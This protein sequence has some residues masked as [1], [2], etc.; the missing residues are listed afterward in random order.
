[1]NK[2]FWIFTC[3]L[4]CAF[5][6]YG[7]SRHALLVGCNYGGDGLERLRYAEKDAGLFA[8][9]LKKAGDFPAGQVKRLLRP[10]R[11]EF[12]KEMGKIG[13]KLQAD[14]DRENSMFLFYFSGH[15][16]GESLLLDREKVSL[17]RIKGFLDSC[18][19]GVRIGVFDA[20]HSGAVT[21]FKGGRASEPLYFTP[22][23]KVKGQVIIAS[24]AAHQ[25]AQESETLKG[26]IFTHHWLNG[27]KGSADHSGD[28]RI[29]LHEAYQYAYRKTVET[30][31]LTGGGIQHPS[32][33]F[34]I[35]G[36]GD[37]C[38][39]DLTRSGM[40][41]VLFDR[42]S[43]GT[44][45]VLSNNY[46]DV[47]A[48]FTKKSGQELFISLTPG[49]YM[50]INARDGDIYTLDKEVRSGASEY[51]THAM[52]KNRP[53]VDA[54]RVK[55]REQKAAESGVGSNERG[56]SI[57]FGAGTGVIS[58]VSRTSESGLL[59]SAAADFS[60]QS[61]LQVF[62]NLHALP[63]SRSAGVEAGMNAWRNVND[64]RLYAGVGPGV[65]YSHL[66]E[67]SQRVGFGIRTHVGFSKRVSSALELQAQI[68]LVFL[69][70]EGSELQTGIEMRFLFGSSR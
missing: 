16:D 33:N 50:I 28:R 64:F 57:S 67:L 22:G 18:G 61:N 34:N 45:L 32:Y 68:P 24:A 29:T 11:S 6:S 26:S 2:L 69:L 9:V 36:E 60:L 54:T 70:V 3:C 47:F 20:C 52:L 66:D 25:R 4:I 43:E 46:T 63:L 1:M 8:E 15:S 7:G 40:E 14:S 31:A 21:A 56:G 17:R 59:L 30:S 65:W 55:G 48:D 49:I 42:T 58:R 38:L 35:Q 10:T 23:E 37:I 13:K 51:V 19:A 27:L 12:W 62:A 44:F 39:T 41:G 5:S 53:L